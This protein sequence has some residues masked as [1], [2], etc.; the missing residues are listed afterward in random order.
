MSLLLRNGFSL[1]TLLYTPDCWRAAEVVVLLGGFLLSTVMLELCQ[2]KHQVIGHLP[3]QGL[4]TSIA[5]TGQP[6]VGRLLAVP[7]FF[8]FQMMEATVLITI[9]NDK[10]RCVPFQIIASRLNLPQVG[11]NQ[12]SETSD[13][14][15]LETGGSW[16]RLVCVMEKAVNTCTCYIFVFHF[17]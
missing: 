2:S 1:A 12:V 17:W 10:D 8:C 14:W 4:F 15:S 16:A 3:D 5:Q 11:P 6:A 9:L 7:Q 13:R